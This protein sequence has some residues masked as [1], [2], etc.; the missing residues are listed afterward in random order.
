MDRLSGVDY[1]GTFYVNDKDDDDFVGFIFSYQNNRNFYLVSWKK[2]KQVYWHNKPFVADGEPGIILKLVQSNTGP[3]ELLRNS[4][5]HKNGHPNQVKILWK[6]PKKMP[7]KPNVSFRWH[8]TH[9][10]KIGLIRFW[11]YEGKTLVADSKNIFDS[12]LQGGRLGVYCL[13]Q[14]NITW[15]NLL[16][17]CRGKGKPDIS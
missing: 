3:G 16:Y 6:E 8:L 14:E 12:T 7:W 13:S 4:L 5:W 15:S 11:M 1:E 2:G 10:P 17:S 9:R